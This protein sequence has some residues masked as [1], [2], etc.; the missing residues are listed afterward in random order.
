V[1]FAVEISLPSMPR[2]GWSP[3]LSDKVEFEDFNLTER[4]TPMT[5]EIWAK[6]GDA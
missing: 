4:E 3:G 5:D 1:E 6:V 2:I